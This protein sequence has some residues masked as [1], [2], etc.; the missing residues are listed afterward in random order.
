M[1]ERIN[2]PDLTHSDE[3]FLHELSGRIGELASAHLASEKEYFP[4]DFIDEMDAAIADGDFI[5]EESPLAEP[6]K[7]ALFVNTLTEDGLPEY[8]STIQRRLPK[9]HPLREWSHFWAADEGRHGPTISGILHKTRQISMRELERARMAMMRYPDTPQPESVIES[10]VYPAIQE[11]AT[12]IAHRNTMRLLPK[13]HKIGRRALGYV[14]GDEVRHGDFYEEATVAAFKVD[15]SLTVI[16]IARQ[17][18]DFAMPGKSIP[19]FEERSKSIEAADI[20]GLKQLRQIYEKLI[21]KR[22]QLFQLEGLNPDAEAARDFIAKRL[23]Q[24]D[25]IIKRRTASTQDRT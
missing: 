25:K 10:L 8:L 12:E 21:E 23:S 1:A 18:R 3:M 5:P 9:K 11:P 15:P 14:I 22:L 13:A 19:G 4:F 6:V 24:M 20:F 7:D 2:F 16:A 17:V